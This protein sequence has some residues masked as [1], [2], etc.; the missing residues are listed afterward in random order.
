[1]RPLGIVLEIFGLYL[2]FSPVIALLKW[3][4][5]VGWLLGGIVAVA[6]FIF[7]L[8]VGLVL[9]CLVIALAWLFYRPLIGISL[10]LLT[11][12]S[13][14]MIFYLFGAEDALVTCDDSTSLDG[15]TGPTVAA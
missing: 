5:L 3:I 14:F 12:G 15:E 13:I 10:L 11:G 2:L 9:A 8:V 6:A 4:P 1:M 7:A